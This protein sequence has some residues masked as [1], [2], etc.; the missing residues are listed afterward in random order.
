MA[1]R[2][3]S[4]YKRLFV[5]WSLLLHLYIKFYQHTL[6]LCDVSMQLILEL[7]YPLNYILL[8]KASQTP[9]CELKNELVSGSSWRWWWGAVR[10]PGWHAST[11]RT[12]RR[13]RLSGP[14]DSWWQRALTMSQQPA[15]RCVYNS[16]VTKPSTE[17][18][19]SQSTFK[20]LKCHYFT[21]LDLKP[22]FCLQSLS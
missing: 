15:A 6:Y 17:V 2:T 19:T 3:L 21:S 11:R 8:V 7:H 14:W 12:A 10:F 22:L 1:A 5:R 18:Q 4:N 16:F 13:M 9:T 20:P